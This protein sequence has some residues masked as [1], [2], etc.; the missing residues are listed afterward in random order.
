MLFRSKVQEDLCFYVFVLQIAI[1][2]ICL[3]SFLPCAIKVC[4]CVQTEEQ[5]REKMDCISDDASTIIYHVE[6]RKLSHWSTH[7][8]FSPLQGH[9]HR[10]G[11]SR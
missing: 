9:R 5:M 11:P 8:G 3:F 2:S 4:G 7:W 6:M 10:G 1:C